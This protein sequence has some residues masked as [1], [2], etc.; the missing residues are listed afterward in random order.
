M[1]VKRV[2]MLFFCIIPLFSG[3]QNYEVNWGE[4]QEENSID[5]I[6]QTVLG[7][8]P[9]HYY[10]TYKRKPQRGVFKYDYHNKLE[11]V[12][13][14]EKKYDNQKIHFSKIINTRSGDYLIGYIHNDI[15][16]KVTFLA[17]DLNDRGETAKNP[18]EIFSYPYRNS[19]FFTSST[20][21]NKSVAKNNDAN[22][23]KVS[24]DSSK[25]I[26]TYVFQLKEKSQGNEEYGIVV[27]DDQ[28]SQLW[29]RKVEF[30]KADKKIRISQ[31]EVSNEG[32]AILIVRDKIIKAYKVFKNEEIKVVGLFEKDIKAFSSKITPIKDGGIA[33]LGFCLLTDEKNKQNTP[34][35]GV[36]MTRFDKNLNRLGSVGRKIDFNECLPK[37]EQKMLA[38]LNPLSLAAIKFNRF[39]IDYPN[40]RIVMAAQFHRYKNATLSYH[41][42]QILVNAFSLNGDHL[43]FSCI[44]KKYT[45]PEDSPS[46]N[47][48]C[49][50]YDH[51][52][53][54]FIYLIDKPHEKWENPE[55]KG[56][57]FSEKIGITKM[58]ER[59][60]IV[61]QS[62]LYTKKT[63][64]LPYVPSKSRGI[65]NGRVLLYHCNNKKARFGVLNI[66]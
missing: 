65:S 63:S 18:K 6:E 54:Y 3:A 17:F 57:L 10:V 52:N 23:I 20:P 40:N 4:I 38:K 43:W 16:N 42:D 21:N 30:P 36:F 61:D 31:Y 12:I 59:G 19:L 45:H 2:V 51:G 33:A 5:Y 28:L 35:V 62:I 22:G 14:T 11:K 25:V 66:N 64:K 56:G 39:F 9:T 15:K 24:Q 58:D 34:S 47:A 1:G 7:T 46:S 32:A 44:N 55:E 26:I 50:G 37:K 60:N 13:L 41:S 49:L 29:E 8:T 48:Y 27:L 53:Y